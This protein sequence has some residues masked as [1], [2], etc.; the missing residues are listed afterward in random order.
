MEVAALKF[1]PFLQPSTPPAI[2]HNESL[3]RW[4]EVVSLERKLDDLTAIDA[5]T[6]QQKGE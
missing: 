4:P 5:I 2:R 3:L 1:S 6:N